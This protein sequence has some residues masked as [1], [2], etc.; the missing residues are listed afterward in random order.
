MSQRGQ[1]SVV[2]S[3]PD[4]GA[5]PAALLEARRPQAGLRV[6]YRTGARGVV[7]VAPR[8]DHRLSVHAGPPIRAVCHNHRFETTRGDVDIVPAGTSAT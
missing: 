3:H 6:D 2:P 8:S 7:E 5:P 4:V 1:L